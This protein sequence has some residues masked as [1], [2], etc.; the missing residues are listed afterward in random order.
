MDVSGQ[1]H[2]ALSFGDSTPGE[3]HL[4]PGG[5][6]RNVAENLARLGLD[7]CL[8]SVVGADAFGDQVLRATQATGVDVSAVAR[9]TG[10]RT[11]VYLSLHAPQGTQSGLAHGINDMGALELLTPEVLATH[12]PLLQ[13]AASL[14]IDC[15]LSAPSLQYVLGF[16]RDQT[17]FVDAVSAAKCLRVKPWLARIHTLKLNAQ[18]AQAL[19]GIG[20][21]EGGEPSRV[22]WVRSVLAQLHSLGAANVVLSLGAYGAAW[23]DAAGNIGEC[24]AHGVNVVNT[25]GAGDALLAGLVFAHLRQLPLAKAVPWALR[26]AEITLQCP[27]ANAVSLSVERVDR[28]IAGEST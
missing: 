7:A 25:T 6:A 21:P 22:S 18:E 23:C 1:S 2:L 27:E 5:V 3:V 17:V 13:S 19:L 28:L 11:G 24:D 8:V 14:V 12:L 20:A 4:S 9:V 26:C 10:A 16:Q 15:N